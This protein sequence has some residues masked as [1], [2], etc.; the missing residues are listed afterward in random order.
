MRIKHCFGLVSALTLCAC[1]DG[2]T[3]FDIGETVSGTVTTDDSHWT[4]C[5][6]SSSDAD[7]NDGYSDHYQADVSAGVTYT[8][9]FTSTDPGVEF[10][11][12]DGGR[13]TGTSG[14]SGSSMGA[15]D[16]PLKW[17]PATSGT[18]AVG[19]YAVS[20]YVPADYTF[21]VTEGY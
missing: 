10:E 14:V 20:S 21:K 1:G 4:S 8:V 9:V 18:H 6:S 5:D 11:D 16:S 15:D 7:C 17:V 3:P 2:R 13:V 19:I 12:V